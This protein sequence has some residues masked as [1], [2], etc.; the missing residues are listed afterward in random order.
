MLLVEEDGLAT[1]SARVVSD[2]KDILAKFGGDCRPGFLEGASVR[3]EKVIPASVWYG[4]AL[5]IG[6]RGMKTPGGNDGA[7]ILMYQPR[8][9]LCI[10]QQIVEVA[11]SNKCS[12][13]S[14]SDKNLSFMSMINWA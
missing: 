9:G 12:T 3:Q 4:E 2:S 14:S 6:A 11:L 10:V 1:V 13:I 8:F 5:G 7:R